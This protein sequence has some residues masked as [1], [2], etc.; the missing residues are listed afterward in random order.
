MVTKSQQSLQEFMEDVCAGDPCETVAAQG[1]I[2]YMWKSMLFTFTR[3]ILSLLPNRVILSL[4][5]ELRI[6]SPSALFSS[7]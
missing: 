5:T 4:R 2:M 1:L 7:R 3:M 6:P